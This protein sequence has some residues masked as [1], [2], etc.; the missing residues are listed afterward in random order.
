MS[1]VKRLP[2]LLLFFLYT[3]SLARM[4][5]NQN[6]RYGSGELLKL[7]HFSFLCPN[8]LKP[9]NQSAILSQAPIGGVYV[10]LGTDRGLFALGVANFKFE[11]LI[12]ADHDPAVIYFNEINLAMIGAAKNLNEYL[13][14][15]FTS[16]AYEFDLNLK[17]LNYMPKGKLDLRSAQHV[18]WFIKRTNYLE[19]EFVDACF[20]GSIGSVYFQNQQHYDGLRK[21][22]LE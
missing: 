19:Q 22:V 2:I 20:D 11:H 12:L 3:K 17:K 15:R 16:N 13:S 6:F 10:A 21:M 14:L 7:G 9:F 5:A 1:L 4:P 8:E 18:R